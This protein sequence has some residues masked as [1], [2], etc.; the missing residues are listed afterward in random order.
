MNGAAATSDNSTKQTCAISDP[1]SALT[2]KRTWGVYKNTPWALSGRT[3]RPRVIRVT[4]SGR[5]VALITS[6]SDF[7]SL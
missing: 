4:R 1:M 7:S 6:A 5:F 2:V 3:V